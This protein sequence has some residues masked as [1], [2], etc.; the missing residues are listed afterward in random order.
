MSA[1]SSFEFPCGSCGKSTGL[2][3]S[4][5]IVSPVCSVCK[6]VGYCDSTC[7][8]SHWRLHKVVCNAIQIF[9]KL[10]AGN[11]ITLDVQPHRTTGADLK[12][13]IRSKTLDPIMVN[14]MVLVY[15]GKVLAN[16][17]TLGDYNIPKEA[18]LHLLV[19]VHRVEEFFSASVQ[20]MKKD[21]GAAKTFSKKGKPLEV[22]V[23]AHSR[24][25]ELRKQIF[26]ALGS[27]DKGGSP[28]MLRVMTDLVLVFEGRELKHSDDGAFLSDIGISKS[29]SA[30]EVFFLAERQQLAGFNA[31]REPVA[32]PS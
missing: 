17:R 18:T 16:D 3:A 9:V 14:E 10:L 32:P 19:A 13:Q 29:N 25:R 21:A 28:D 30:L 2:F 27:S 20:L 26:V 12:A 8:R 11:S 23:F 15:G 7:Q 5:R 22:S 4:Q 6:K 1:T 31:P 24:L